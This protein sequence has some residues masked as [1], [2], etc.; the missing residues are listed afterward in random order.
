MAH[1]HVDP[2]AEPPDAVHEH[3]LVAEVVRPAALCMDHAYR[4]R[5]R[6]VGLVASA[7]VVGVALLL[8]WGTGSAIL[9]GLLAASV[10]GLLDRRVLIAAGLSSLACCTILLVAEQH[11]WLERSP[12][13][14]YYAANFGI[15]SLTNAVNALTLWAFFLFGSGLV[16]Y[17]ARQVAGAQGH[18]GD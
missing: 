9:L 11:A 2:G 14:N 18:D 13:V 1:R 6:G 7:F 10:S 16:T 8:N 12:L 3:R 4:L 5:A 15:Y 17:I